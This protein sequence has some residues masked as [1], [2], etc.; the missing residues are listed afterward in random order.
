MPPDLW[1]LTNQ[2]YDLAEKRLERHFNAKA[3]FAF[4]LHL[5]STLER[6]KDGHTIVHPD[7]NN[8]RK[9]LK[10]EFQVA[11]DLSTI[12]EEECHVEI[13]FDEIGFISMFLSIQ[14]SE[15]DKPADKGVEVVVLMHGKLTA[16]S[17]LEA[18]QELLETTSGVGMNM[19]LDMEVQEMYRLLLDY[20]LSEKSTCKT[21]C[22]Y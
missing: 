1:R 9:N 4:A 11:L 17:M 7:L 19:R 8:V 6:L 21:D 13:P 2:L 18:A 20:V 10:K 3:R 14:V 12:L 22:Y 5:Q 16:T 15:A